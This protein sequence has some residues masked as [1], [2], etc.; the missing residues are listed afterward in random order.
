MKKGMKAVLIALVAIFIFLAGYRLIKT[1]L[2]VSSSSWAKDYD[3][4]YSIL[5]ANLDEGYGVVQTPDKGYIVTGVTSGDQNGTFLVMRLTPKGSV[6]WAKQFGKSE[7]EPTCLIK[8]NDNCYLIAGETYSRKSDRNLFLV[9]IDLDGNMKWS[10]SYGRIKTEWFDFAGLD[11]SKLTSDL[12]LGSISQTIDGGFVLSGGFWWYGGP[13]DYMGSLDVFYP[14]II[15]ID[16]DG[17][18][19]WVKAFEGNSVDLFD[20]TSQ[21]VDSGFLTVKMMLNYHDLFVMKLSPN[22]KV[23]WS[24]I[25]EGGIASSCAPT[26]DGGA[27]VC[28]SYEK[29]GLK[30]SSASL[31]IRINKDG[32]VLWAKTYAHNTKIGFIKSIIKTADGNFV[33]LGTTS[34][35][36]LFVLKADEKGSIKWAKTFG[37]GCESVNYHSGLSSTA[38]GGFIVTGGTECFSNF[39]LLNFDVGNS[40]II[41]A[42]FD[43]DGN[44]GGKCGDSFGPYLQECSPDI[45]LVKLDEKILRLVSSDATFETIPFSPEVIKIR[46]V[47]VRTIC[48]G[49]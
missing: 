1:D 17:E 40:D 19:E 29:Q 11:E 6:I 46:N 24:K 48:K 30:N 45:S 13:Q 32:E 26:E 43:K 5:A 16:K 31:L 39:S 38:D 36:R 22:G 44:I 42:K 34:K 2:F 37:S 28:G 8:T 7:G 3:I 20:Y 25:L 15:K 41:V 21:T 47:H 33:I 9:K 49:R 10:K 27:I 12:L 14:I 23:E 35:D 4:D 18:I